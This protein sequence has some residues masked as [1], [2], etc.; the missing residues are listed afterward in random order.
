MCRQDVIKLPQVINKYVSQLLNVYDGCI[1]Y[2][3]GKYFKGKYTLQV[4]TKNKGNN[5]PDTL[6]NQF[7]NNRIIY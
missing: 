3:K 2:S 7:A 1:N 6:K 4:N 5:M